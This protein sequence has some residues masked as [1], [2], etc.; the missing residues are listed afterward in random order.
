MSTSLKKYAII[1]YWNNVSF[2]SRSFIHKWQ[3][4]LRR[5]DFWVMKL[6]TL[7]PNG[8]NETLNYPMC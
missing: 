8:F 7:Q 5:E 3:L 1:Y 4:L 2:S 6:S